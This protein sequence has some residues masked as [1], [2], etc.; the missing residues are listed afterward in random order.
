MMKVWALTDPG[1]V[2]HQNQDAYGVETVDGRTVSVVCDGM[3]GPKNGDIAS[4][5]AV[6]AFL[7]AVRTHLRTDMTAEQI[8][9]MASYAVSVAN[10][11][12]RAAVEEHPA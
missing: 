5:I 8:R 10:M 1:L 9:E 4:K 2:R 7:T 3:G 6:E 12:I 11:D